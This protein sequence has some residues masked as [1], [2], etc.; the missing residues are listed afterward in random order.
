MIVKDSAGNLNAIAVR[1]VEIDN[2]NIG[3]VLLKLPYGFCSVIGFRNNPRT[4]H[5]INNT[6][7]TNP[8]NGMIVG[9]YYCCFVNTLHFWGTLTVKALPE[10]KTE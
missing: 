6:F 8:E 1:H 3:P 10:P 5:A 9:D 2:C 4:F 7:Q